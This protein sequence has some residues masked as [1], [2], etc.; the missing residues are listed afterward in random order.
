MINFKRD[1]KHLLLK[2]SGNYNHLRK[3]VNCTK[4]WYGNNYGGFYVCPEFLNEKSIVYSFGIGEDISFDKSI[5]KNHDCSVFGFDPTPKSID[6]VSHQKLPQKFFFHEFGISNKSGLVDFYLPKNP[7]YVSGSA[8][9]QS[10]ITLQE[11]VSV[12]MKSISE[13]C[14]ELGHNKVDLLKMDIEGSEYSVI[15]DILSSK[16]PIGQ[17]LVEFHDRFFDNG[18]NKTIEAVNQL[19]KYGYQIF[20]SSASFEEISFIN[21]NILNL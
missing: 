6:W 16:I 17:I 12:R 14:A 1:V 2:L 9:I 15:E 4:A 3:G 19:N 11:R 13:I 5:I 20:A 8:V 21:K 18:R 7:S 10:N